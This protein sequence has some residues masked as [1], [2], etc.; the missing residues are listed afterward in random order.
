MAEGRTGLA[1]GPGQLPPPAFTE[2]NFCWDLETVSWGPFTVPRGLT[3][4]VPGQPSLSLFFFF[5]LLFK[6][7]PTAYG[8]SQARGRIRAT[9]ASLC[10]S[11]GNA[12][13]LTH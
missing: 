1:S 6:A 7:T 12:G 9:A 13:S 8:D 2:H 11:H 10:H 5:F 3:V 4:A